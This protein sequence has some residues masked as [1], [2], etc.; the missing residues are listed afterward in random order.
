MFLAAVF[1]HDF[2]MIRFVDAG[3]STSFCVGLTGLA[4]SSPPQFGHFNL[5]LSVA[6][7]S[8]NV[9]S[10]EQIIAPTAS[11]GK[12]LSQHSQF[13]LIS[14]MTHPSHD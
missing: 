12:S 8:Q 5:N 14:S 9:H 6:H 2:V 7:A 10:N 13:G 1:Q 11:A 4:T 3:F